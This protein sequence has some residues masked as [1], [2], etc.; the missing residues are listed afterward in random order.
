M[1]PKTTAGLVWSHISGFH[2]TLTQGRVPGAIIQ[3]IITANYIK[4]SCNSVRLR[5][6]TS[7]GRASNVRKFY[8]LF[9]L[10]FKLRLISGVHLSGPPGIVWIVLSI[11]PIVTQ[12][13]ANTPS[14]LLKEKKKVSIAFEGTAWLLSQSVVSTSKS[15][16]DSENLSSRLSV[17]TTVY[18]LLAICHA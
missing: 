10:L 13:F 4:H 16:A 7:I 9:S 14:F 12:S 17:V 3:N 18:H 11:C 2:S 1:S 15:K 5:F 6:W 8:L